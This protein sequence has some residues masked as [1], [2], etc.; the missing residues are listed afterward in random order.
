MSLSND[1]PIMN[2]SVIGIGDAGNKAVEN[3]SKE[4]FQGIKLLYL[5]NNNELLSNKDKDSTIFLNLKNEES[6]N[7]N[8]NIG[9]IAANDSINEIRQKL[10]D[11]KLLILTAG[12]G[13]NIGT[14]AL[15][16]VARTAKEMGI[17]TIAIVTTPFSYEGTTKELNARVGLENLKGNADIVIV[18]S[19]DRLINN[20]PD[21]AAI[22]A[23][24]LVNNIVKNCVRTF[25]NLITK[26]SVINLSIIDIVNAIKD[27]GEAYI[28]FG[29]G[30]GRNKIMR[31]ING[32][33]N[34]K[35]IE[36]SIKNSTNAIL[37]IVGDPTVTMQQ[38]N[39]IITLF[40]QKVKNDQMNIVFGFDVNPNLRNEIQ[41]SIIATFD[42]TKAIENKLTNEQLLHNSQEL[43]IEIGNTLENELNAY[44]T[45]E[46]DIPKF[47][48]EKMNYQ[49]D[50][51][52]Q[53]SFL[54]SN[55][56]DA[57]DDIPFFLK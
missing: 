53:E 5:N 20:Y 33:L 19:N 4:N 45:G 49:Y 52:D 15:P 13:G 28:G 11:T 32:A 48:I 14:G 31:A 17:L 24:K 23:F 42:K 3:I 2:I 36:T 9:K 41:I 34:S 54:I 25:V 6:T 1:K 8:W 55:E 21:I 46:L 27:K 44:T 40:K 39:E 56:E 26:S 30:V 50:D 51:K 18:I 22:D 7:K 35:I 37:Y 10:V 29:S 43:L 38:I 47:D 16:V 57:E 12:F